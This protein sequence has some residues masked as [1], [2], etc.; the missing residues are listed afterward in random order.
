M[1]IKSEVREVIPLELH[2]LFCKPDNGENFRRQSGQG[3]ENEIFEEMSHFFQ[4]LDKLSPDDTAFCGTQQLSGK[5]ASFELNLSRF[6][7]PS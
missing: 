6:S 1:R 2:Q 5:S 3:V 7:K 4:E